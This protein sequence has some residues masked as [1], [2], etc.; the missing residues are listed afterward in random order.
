M[1]KAIMVMVSK[2]ALAVSR[3]MPARTRE[4]IAPRVEILRSLR[5]PVR[6]VG[7][8][9]SD[10]MEKACVK[11]EKGRTSMR[12]MAGKVMMTLTTVMPRETWALRSGEEGRVLDRMLL[13]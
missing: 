2:R 11:G 9:V 12:K 3:A 4:M 7:S 8:G 5:R 6:W 13:L 1:M 10:T